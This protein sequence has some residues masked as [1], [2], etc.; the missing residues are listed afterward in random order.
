[1]NID[2]KQTKYLDHYQCHKQEM[3]NNI[4]ESQDYKYNLKGAKTLNITTV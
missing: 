3:K 4:Q 2:Q 1:M